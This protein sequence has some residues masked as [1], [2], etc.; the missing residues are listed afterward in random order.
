MMRSQ[1]AFWQDL[2]GLLRDRRNHG[3]WVAYHGGERVGLGASATEL[4]QRCLGRGLPRGAFYV[5]RIEERDTPPWGAAP[6][7]KSL[8]EAGDGPPPDP[9]PSPR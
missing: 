2:P 6:L 8:Y 3:R 5:G 1:E 4:Y 9:G 7:E